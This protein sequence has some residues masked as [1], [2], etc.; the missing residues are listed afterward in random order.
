MGLQA[1][2]SDLVS[3]P[4]RGSCPC[5]GAVLAFPE[6]WEDTSW[7]CC[8]LPNSMLPKWGMGWPGKEE[9][10]EGT[11]WRGTLP[12]ALPPSLPA[13]PAH[14][15]TCAPF[16][17]HAE[18]P[19]MGWLEK[20]HSSREGLCQTMFARTPDLE[21]CREGR[22]LCLPPS[23]WR[24][25]AGGGEQPASQAISPETLLAALRLPRIGTPIVDT[26]RL[27]RTD[28]TLPLAMPCCCGGRR[29]DREGIVVEG[30][31]PKLPR[32]GGGDIQDSPLP[33]PLALALP[34]EEG[35]GTA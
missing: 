25:G 31:A 33:R 18:F 26:G 27:R 20:G 13:C 9:E 23:G 1:L 19:T 7:T 16:P 4:P 17:P 22:R 6:D 21:G 11:G 15:D 12:S 32:R 14:C 29:E 28:R 2:N 8:L 35:W 10:E 5:L 24:T 34:W 30:P 3:L